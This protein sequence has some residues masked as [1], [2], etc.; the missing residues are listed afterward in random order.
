MN[1][2]RL[3]GYALAVFVLLNGCAKKQG[4]AEGK[5]KSPAKIVVQ[6]DWVAEPEH[7][8]L[9]QALAKGF[10]IEAGLDVT[11]NQGGANAYPLQKVATGV[12]Q[13]AQSDSTSVLQAINEGLPL[14]NI[15]AV[16][17]HDPSVFMLHEENPISKWEELNGK[18]VMARPEYVFLPYLKKKYGIDFKVIPQ[19][20]GL[21]QFVADKN[22][23][24]QGFYIAEPF[25]L[26]KNGAKPKW[27]YVW[28]AGF[29]AY[30]II[31]SNKDF[32]K[33]NPEVTRKFIAAYIRGLRDYIEG[34]PT[35][36]HEMM[37]KINPKAAQNLVEF[38][39]FLN[40]SRGQ[41]IKE[42]LADGHRERG[43]TYGKITA[44]RFANQIHQL[45]DI[46]VLKKGKLTAADVMTDVYL[47]K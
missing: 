23:I 30:T 44:E 28:D 26:I 5:E 6:L 22:F 39:E 36:A 11:L 16:F 46:D 41:I 24:Q 9:Y 21:G 13:F 2:T 18:T 34:D 37:A 1:V 15:A 4:P 8:G 10:F 38:K 14:I 25:Y 40:F 29:D 12:A 45:E 3:V 35:P 31:F 27:L 7:G 19:N 32:V 20:F 43:E 42:H 47:P 33:N 17:Q